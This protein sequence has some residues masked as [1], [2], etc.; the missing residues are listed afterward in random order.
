M[1]G[2]ARI[3]G[4][5]EVVDELGCCV[6]ASPLHFRFALDLRF[7]QAFCSV[8]FCPVIATRDDF[9]YICIYSCARRKSIYFCCHWEGTSESKNQLLALRMARAREKKLR[10]PDWKW[11][12]FGLCFCEIL[13]ERSLYLSEIAFP[14]HCGPGLSD[15][16]HD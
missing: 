9:V 12:L 13:S 14:R 15:E 2:I 6:S 10:Y 7:E 11:R 8:L 3:R 4:R 1:I 5:N 16:F